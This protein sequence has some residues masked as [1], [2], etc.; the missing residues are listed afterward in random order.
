MVHVNVGGGGRNVS[1]T[2]G[3][4]A[5]RAKIKET[6]LRM[7]GTLTVAIELHI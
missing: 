4:L 7:K 5:A 2:K 6:Q 1:N 3:P